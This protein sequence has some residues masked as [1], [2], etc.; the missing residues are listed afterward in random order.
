MAVE[1]FDASWRVPKPI[2]AETMR[3]ARLTIAERMRKQGFANREILD[4][5][6]MLGVR[7]V[8]AE[9]IRDVQDEVRK[10]LDE[11]GWNT[12]INTTPLQLV[13]L[14]VFETL[15]VLADKGFL[16]LDFE[17]VPPANSEVKP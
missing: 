9:N 8:A 4:T 17:K 3:K 10:R 1:T 11:Q 12:R 2:D 14:I 13:N 7:D 5:I 15:K 16:E 6:E